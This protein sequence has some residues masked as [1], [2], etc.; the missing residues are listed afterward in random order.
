MEIG[1]YRFEKGK[2]A[3]VTISNEGA[4]GMVVADAV[5]FVKDFQ[6]RIEPAIY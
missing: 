3:N 1:T 2:A 4:D 5:A 6:A